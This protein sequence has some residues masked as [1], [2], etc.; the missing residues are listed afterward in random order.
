MH[1]EHNKVVH[2]QVV[3][4]HMVVCRWCVV[5]VSLVWCVLVCILTRRDV[6]TLRRVHAS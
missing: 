1:L 4:K 6:G 3:H 5:G 2:I